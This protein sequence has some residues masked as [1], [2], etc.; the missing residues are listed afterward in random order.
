MPSIPRDRQMEKMD[1][2]CKQELWFLRHWKTQEVKPN[3]QSQI[4]K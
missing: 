4:G 1:I 3:T 2:A